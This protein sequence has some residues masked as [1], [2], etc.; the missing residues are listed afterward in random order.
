MS[1]FSVLTILFRLGNL[2]L[3]VV[4]FLIGNG[5]GLCFG[6]AYRIARMPWPLSL[7]NYRSISHSLH[8]WGR[9]SANST[10]FELPWRIQMHKT[11]VRFNMKS[12]KPIFMLLNFVLGRTLWKS[13]GISTELNKGCC[14]TKHL[15]MSLLPLRCHL[16]R[17]R[18][19]H[20][21]TLRLYNIPTPRLILSVE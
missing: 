12:K 5:K 9:S 19:S 13:T 17:Q 6:S 18:V 1:A 4:L 7:G 10:P 8:Q 3:A 16:S 14:T 11:V 21:E 15:N 2:R 20:P